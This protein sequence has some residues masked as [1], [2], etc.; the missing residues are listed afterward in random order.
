MKDLNR[1][2]FIKMSALGSA[3]P[4]SPETNS[5]IL[6]ESPMVNFVSDGLNLSPSQYLK[7]LN[8]I[9]ETKGIKVDNYSLNGIVEEFEQKFAKLVG[10][11]MAIFLP[12]GT[13]AN[14]LAIRKLCGDS[15][16][17]IVQN[18]SH[19]Y[20]DSGDCVQSLSQINLI[21][22][23]H[24]NASFSLEEVQ[25]LFQK[26]ETNRVKTNI[27]VISIESPVRRKT[28]ELF[29]FAEMQKI[30]A[31]AKEK[32]IKMHLDGARIFLAS[33]YTGIRPTE[34]ASHFDT[35][36][37]SLYKY[38]NA[39]SGAILAG[40]KSVIEGMFH[41]RRMFGSG[42]HQ[43]WPFVAA[44][45]Y[46]MEGFEKRYAIAKS[47]SDEFIQKLKTEERFKVNRIENGSNIF[48]LELSA[49]SAQDFSQNLK[50][51]DIWAN[52]KNKTSLNLLVNES[53]N[54]TSANELFT[55]FK[56]ALKQ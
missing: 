46:F 9:I 55:K 31:F 20:N 1:R 5:P 39:A 8:Q 49:I 56:N 22:L 27:G 18:Q 47:I 3:I 4:F 24:E 19:I 43:S 52:P 37:V 16:R 6:K 7:V 23:G 29:D 54:S 15:K 40:P 44:A 21:P 50:K 25:E 45:D 30:S 41:T 14:Q 10:K 51:Q 36:Y 12:T 34:Y 17:A 26:N 11:E 53:L 28:G 2:N 35:V 13:L 33:A 38:F 32:N 42:L 48:N